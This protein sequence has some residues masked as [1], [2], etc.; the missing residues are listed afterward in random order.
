MIKPIIEC[1]GYTILAENEENKLIGVTIHYDK[2]KDKYY[3]ICPKCGHFQFVAKKS[4]EPLLKKEPS[5]IKLR[6]ETILNN[7]GSGDIK[8][9]VNDT[10]FGNLDF[11]IFEDENRIKI[12]YIE[13]FKKGLHIGTEM[14]NSLKRVSVQNG[15]N[16]IYGAIK[17]GSQGFYEKIGAEIGDAAEILNDEDRKG[18]PAFRITIK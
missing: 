18:Q 5:C 10:I 6:I 12:Q 7:Y 4:I 11:A 13:S 2:N 16:E 8:A 3:V 14:I 17:T 15:I 1:C 9:Y